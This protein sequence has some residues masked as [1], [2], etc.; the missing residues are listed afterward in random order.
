VVR[1][2]NVGGGFLEIQCK[3]QPKALYRS[4]TTRCWKDQLS[5]AGVGGVGKRVVPS[6]V[7]I[8]TPPCPEGGVAE[9]LVADGRAHIWPRCAVR[10]THRQNLRLCPFHERA[11]RA[12]LEADRL[13]RTSYANIRQ[14]EYLVLLL[15]PDLFSF[16]ALPP[17]TQQIC[18]YRYIDAVLLSVYLPFLSTLISLPFTSYQINRLSSAPTNEKFFFPMFATAFNLAPA[19]SISLPQRLYRYLRA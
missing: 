11:Q 17:N 18:H 4:A 6:Q 5:C 16:P 7:P 2:G 19:T 13:R 12:I 9:P 1:Q 14:S 10:L 8:V 3:F 15:R